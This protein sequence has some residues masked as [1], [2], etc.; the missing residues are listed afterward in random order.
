MH[1]D[2]LPGIGLTALMI[3][4]HHTVDEKAGA[5]LQLVEGSVVHEHAAARQ[6]QHHQIGF[7]I[8]TAGHVAFAKLQI[9][10]FLHIEK[11]R[12]GEGAGRLNPPPG[13]F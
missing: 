4:G 10:G 7:Q 11:G 2:E 9:T 1:P 5:L 13:A 6:H 8:L 12:A 3:I